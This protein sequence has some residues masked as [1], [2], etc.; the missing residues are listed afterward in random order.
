MLHLS[1]GIASLILSLDIHPSEVTQRSIFGKL[2]TPR[3][4]LKIVPYYD[5]DNIIV[6]KG[7]VDHAQLRLVDA[8]LSRVVLEYDACRLE[9]LCVCVVAAVELY[10]H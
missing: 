1:S 6:L 2:K 8:V 10:P 3:F 5:L 9:H 7:L 4:L